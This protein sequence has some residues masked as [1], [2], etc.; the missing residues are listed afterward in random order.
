M[1]ITVISPPIIIG[2]QG[3]ANLSPDQQQ[4]LVSTSLIVCGILSSIQITRFHIYKSPYY[5]GTGLI[6]VYVALYTQIVV[7]CSARSLMYPALGPPSPSS[8]WRPVR[9]SRCMPT[10]YVQ[11]RPVVS[12]CPV[13]KVTAR[14]LELLAFVPSWRSRCPSCH[15]SCFRSSSRLWSLGLQ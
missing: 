7:H 5:L 10:A 8:L 15:P 9:W 14:F 13:R 4:Y 12:S 6:S 2:G 1:S 3:G 11:D